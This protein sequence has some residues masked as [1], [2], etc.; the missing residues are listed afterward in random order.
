MKKTFKKS[1]CLY[2]A[3]VLSA[4]LDALC[5]GKGY[6]YMKLIELS[7]G[8]F[9]KVDDEDY[10]YLNQFSW[11]YTL[12][13]KNN[14]GYAMRSDR[15][16]D[17]KITTYRMH[18][19]IMNLK[20]KDG[21]IVDHKDGDGINNQKENLRIATRKQNAS[22]R[23]FPFGTSKFLGVSVNKS[24]I[25]G[26]EYIYWISTIM[27]NGKK[28]TIKRFPYTKEGEVL[29]ALAYNDVAKKLNGEFAS[30]NEI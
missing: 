8:K 30:L 27:K 20:S 1:L 24:I 25:K 14:T 17:G 10:D 21:I 22:N 2:I 18:R 15:S 26:K 11:C 3:L 16:K 13:K 9:A 5:I 6:F 7:Q 28:L 29:A 12:G 4:Q 19:E 23:K